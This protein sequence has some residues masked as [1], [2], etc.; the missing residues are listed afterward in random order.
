MNL[1]LSLLKRIKVNKENDCWEAQGYLDKDGY[2]SITHKAR[3]I[4]RVSYELFI[5]PIPRS[6]SVLH[7]CD[8]PRCCNPDHLFL[9][10]Q[11]DNV[12][13]MIKKGRKDSRFGVRNTQNKLTEQQVFE[14]YHS[15]D[16]QR[17]VAEKYGIDQSTVSYIKTGKLWGWLTKA[18]EAS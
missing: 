15:A 2:A 3:R 5:G 10:T 17:I 11:K 13:D 14:I 4:H 16:A 9:G 18:G 7:K 12:A 1:L 8:N 6:L